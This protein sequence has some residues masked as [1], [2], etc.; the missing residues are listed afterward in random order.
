MISTTHRALFVHIPKCG[1]QSVERFFLR[2]LGLTWE[3]RD[4][5]QLRRND[6]P[7]KGPPRLAHM[8]A[9]EYVR[10]GYLSAEE[11]QRYYKFAFVRNPWARLVSEYRYR[12]F[13]VH[14]YDFKTFVLRRFPT[15]GWSDVYRHVMPQVDYLTDADGRLL[16]D[17]I[18]KL[19]SFS[20]DFATICAA[21]GFPKAELPRTNVT[22][23]ETGGLFSRNMLYRLQGA[24]HG[25]FGAPEHR[26]YR[27]Y[28]DDE[29]REHVA[30]YYRHDIKS[31]GYGFDP[32]ATVGGP[33][34]LRASGAPAD[35]GVAAPLNG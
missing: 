16:V 17:F 15:P 35:L 28:Y 26:D 14:R 22:K 6:D 18:G 34:A 9:A 11:F 12:P 30:H 19:E 2:A 7:S 31:F 29:T 32:P 1:G 24:L 13:H 25:Y 27:D 3:Q 8:T 5:L 33:I 23:V 20:A 21:L 10:W 4:Q